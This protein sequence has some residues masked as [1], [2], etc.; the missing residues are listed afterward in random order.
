MIFHLVPNTAAETKAT[1]QLGC[2]DKGWV[3]FGKGSCNGTF[4]QKGREETLGSEEAI[5]VHIPICYESLGRETISMM[6]PA[7]CGG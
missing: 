5:A 4:I 1:F 7:V 6:R 2:Q 3:E